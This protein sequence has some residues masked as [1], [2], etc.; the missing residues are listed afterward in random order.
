[1]REQSL[2]IALDFP[3]QKETVNFLKGFK[4]EELFVKV[5]M[6]LFYQNGPA[7]LSV[8]KT[9]GHQ[10]FLDLKL[11]D[12]PNTVKQAMKGLASL[13]V[14]IVNVHAAGG[15][16]MM[17]AAIEGLD[18]GTKNGVPRPLC[19]AV[20]QL[21]STTE[22]Q[23][24][25]EQLIAGSLDNSVFHYAKLAK[26]AG[27]DGVVC[28]PHE[29]AGIHQQSGSSFLTVTPGIRQLADEIHDQQR[30]A[31][32]ETARQLGSDY[33]VVGRSITKAADPIS[34]YHTIRNAWEGVQI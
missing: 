12:I 6:E 8:I 11:H 25:H 10:I 19:I 23:M 1:M 17:S 4:G 13:G 26:A 30:I 21:T 14:D 24:N 5:G 27:L 18:A 16:A 32:P 28:S 2:I 7:I 34:A 15:T 22:E 29:A 20:T 9:M 3:N 33:I 31:T